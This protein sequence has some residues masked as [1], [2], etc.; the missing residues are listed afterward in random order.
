MLNGLHQSLIIE[1]YSNIKSMTQLQDDS[2]IVEDIHEISSSQ[3]VSSSV[4]SSSSSS[5]SIPY[6]L[7]IITI[8]SYLRIVF[9][10][11]ILKYPIRF[12]DFYNYDINVTK[13]SINTLYID[14]S[15]YHSDNDHSN[16]YDDNE[17]DDNIYILEQNKVNQL[18]YILNN[19]QLQLVGYQHYY[20]YHK[21]D[22][23]HDI[24]DNRSLNVYINTIGFQKSFIYNYNHHD[25]Y[26]DYHQYN[27]DDNNTIGI[28][29]DQHQLSSITNH[30]QYHSWLYYEVKKLHL[31][32]YNNHDYN[33]SNHNNSSSSCT[34]ENDNKNSK[35]RKKI[36]LITFFDSKFH[37]INMMNDKS[38]RW[39]DNNLDRDY[40]SSRCNS[41]S[42][43]SSNSS[44]SYTNN[45]DSFDCIDYIISIRSNAY[46]IY[47]NSIYRRKNCIYDDDEYDDDEGDKDDTEEDDKN[48]DD[49]ENSNG[50]SAEIYN[51]DDNNKDNLDVDAPAAVD[52]YDDDFSLQHKLLTRLKY[53]S[54]NSYLDICSH[55]KNYEYLNNDNY[56][57]HGNYP[58]HHHHQSIITAN[59]IGGLGNQLFIIFTVI[60]HSIKYNLRYEFIYSTLSPSMKKPRPTYW[61]NLLSC[62]K[63][64]KKPSYANNDCKSESKYNNMNNENDNNYNDH[65]QQQQQQ[66]YH[67]KKS[68]L[69]NSNINRNCFKVYDISILNELDGL[70]YQKLS[71]M[72]HLKY[73]N[74]HHHLNTYDDDDDDD[75]DDIHHDVDDGNND[76]YNNDEFK[77]KYIILNGYF[78]HKQYFDDILNKSM[79]SAFLWRGISD[80][81]RLKI[82]EIVS[83]ID[84]ISIGRRKIFIHIR[85]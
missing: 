31:L 29:N 75:D 38:C 24:Y 62:L 70:N 6:Q 13:H 4:P 46:N 27:R 30:H 40:S 41:K 42:G 53:Y 25:L 83:T 79:I 20:Y 57:N 36:V 81:D 18:R 49:I 35:E 56:H 39:K 48:S 74:H 55:F 54:T 9:V 45:F 50:G 2:I 69:M 59:I 60:A 65:H 78:Q 61:D 16:S 11:D 67:E 76:K 82:N 5:S 32:L 28:I 47:V 22:H 77:N 10:K 7:N 58:F 71:I 43:G 14:I 51:T 19:T 17:D 84:E 64:L 3:S 12:I 21:N 85:R 80:D 23:H 37:I 63:T 8:D 1:P 52:D 33:S 44:S 68:Y 15:S 73:H 34:S 66:Q 72:E 26:H